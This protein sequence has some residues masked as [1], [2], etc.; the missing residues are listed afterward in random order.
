[1]K[2]TRSPS[3]RELLGTLGTL[4]VLGMFSSTPSKGKSQ[5]KVDA[6]TGPTF[7]ARSDRQEYARLKSMDLDDPEIV[8]RQKKMP[9][10]KI[11]TLSVGRLISGSN[12]ISMNMHARDLDYV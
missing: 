4:P 6:V 2:L 1:M 11:G 10:G 7:I 3:R 12:L 8:A 9:V 5:D